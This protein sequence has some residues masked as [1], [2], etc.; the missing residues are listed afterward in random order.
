[1][2]TFPVMRVKLTNEHIMSAVFGVLI[3]Y[4][5]PNWLYEP[6]GVLEFTA[7]VAVS[8]IIDTTINILRFKR[9]VCAVS[10]A[11]T[12]AILYILTTGVPLWG[13]LL[14]IV[15]ALTIGKHIWG[16]T[17]KNIVNPALVGVLFIS[18]F[19]A[20][21]EP[22]FNATLLLLPAII[23]S[24]PFISFRPFAALGFMAGMVA[25]MLF[26]QDL[27][28]T[29]LIVYGVF[30]WGCLVITDPVTIT[31]KPVT[32]IIGGLLAGFLTLLFSPS[33]V[34]TA[35]GI[36]L[37]NFISAASERF[38]KTEA[39]ISLSRIRRIKVKMFR[40]CQ[41]SN[42]DR[43][44][45]TDLTGKEEKEEEEE[46]E[47]EVENTAEDGDVASC[48]EI[49]RRIEANEVY[50]FGGAAF[51]TI[52]KIKSV[53]KSGEPQKKL[54]INGVECDPGLIHDK[55]LMQ[56]HLN[57]ICIGIDILQSCIK[58]EKIIFAAKDT[59]DLKCPDNVLLYKV[60]DYYPS[61]AEKILIR[62]VLGNELS[63]LDIPAEKGILVLNLQTVY[64]LYEAV[65]K[66]KKADTK[67]IT[68]A[69]LKS[70]AWH[71]AKVRLGT[72][73]QNVVE[74][75]GLRPGNVFWGGGAMQCST[76]SDD[77]VI[78][79]SLNFIAVGDYPNYKESPQCSRCGLC[80]DNC[81]AGI[82]ADRIFDL[83]DE[84]N[85]KEAKKY[86]PETCIQCCN[87][88]RVCLAGRN[89][90]VRVKEVNQRVQ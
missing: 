54:I 4:M 36:L 39:S 81:P 83:V 64:S 11:V 71:I 56:N 77:D 59:S 25:A 70:K 31:A 84:G 30:F 14:G 44:A 22:A 9:P 66:N 80:K 43:A 60:P 38:Y 82:R 8:L 5:L 16:G 67:F 35:I 55:W 37:L 10:A 53:M 88:S 49:F 20:M 75:L 46:G 78:G 34:V 47:E 6:S 89:L 32:G 3:L 21:T 45:F 1:M 76:V 13:Q 72:N 48:E 63:P 65:S 68:V 79:S 52:R 58:F 50:G 69:D 57:E 90:A 24:L 19:F 87:C 12:A 7:V 27:N 51:P 33:V 41:I 40:P 28:F 17:G 29:N 85:W 74:T 2:N 86:K 61:G 23:L 26:S 73:I 62:Q 42:I 15:A 18:L